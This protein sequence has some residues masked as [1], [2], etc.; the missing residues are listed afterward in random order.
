MLSTVLRASKR[1]KKYSVYE[2]TR[3]MTLS[4]SITVGDLGDMKESGSSFPAG[5][6]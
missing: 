3:A 6:T 4:V 1:W 5:G 2:I